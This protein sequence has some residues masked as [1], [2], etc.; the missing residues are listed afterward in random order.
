[1]RC[2]QALELKA[3]GSQDRGW[4]CSELQASLG[5]YMYVLYIKT[6]SYK[7]KGGGA[8]RKRKRKGQERKRKKKGWRRKEGRGPCG[9]PAPFCDVEVHR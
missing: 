4:L 8:K 7:R 1:M 6:L 5:Y 3:G 9:I 2:L